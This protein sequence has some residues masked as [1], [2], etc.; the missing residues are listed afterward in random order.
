MLSA[1]LYYFLL[2]VCTLTF[3]LSTIY[4]SISRARSRQTYCVLI[5]KTSLQFATSSAHTNV[6]AYG[7]L[8]ICPIDSPIIDDIAISIIG[9]NNMSVLDF[10]RCRIFVMLRSCWCCCCCDWF[11][12]LSKEFCLSTFCLLSDRD[13]RV[14]V[15]VSLL[16]TVACCGSVILWYLRQCIC[17]YQMLWH[18]LCVLVAKL[19]RPCLS[20]LS[21]GNQ[22]NAA[23]ILLFYR[24]NDL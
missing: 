24:K 4:L 19:N 15:V 6:F 7:S 11:S 12:T 17:P 21:Y 20:T 23:N 9:T 8:T 22:K 5:N 13:R 2:I 18:S 16:V 1:T 3:S 10:N 14:P